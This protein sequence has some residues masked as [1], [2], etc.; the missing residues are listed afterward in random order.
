MNSIIA[1]REERV[2]FG[3]GI[4][5]LSQ[6][7]FVLIDPSAKWLAA[8][9]IPTTEIIFVRYAVHLALVV[10]FFLPQRGRALVRTRNLRLELARGVALLT[11]TIFAFLAVRSLPVTM[12]GAIAFTLPLIVC[13]LSIPMLGEQVGWRRWSA[14]VVG[15]AGVL[16]VIQ[17]G[18]SA[19]NPAVFLSLA[20]A[21]AGAVY[22][23]LTRKLAGVDSA[24]TQQF[25]AAALA[26]CCI[27]PFAFG[28]WVWPTDAP[29]WF[30]FAV[31]GIAGMLGHQLATVAA[32]FAPASVLAPF[33]Y[34][35]IVY[36]A[37]IS[38]LIF[39]QP[40]TLWI[41]L[42]AAIVIASGLYMGLRERKL[43][44]PITP[45]VAGT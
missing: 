30:A 25:Y 39:N 10:G 27:T 14:I 29:T 42:G 26:L 19:F 13:M 34:L 12:T 7:A 8:A 44:K 37:I 24:S 22:N 18:T 35:Q 36:L 16:V 45:V 43:S 2:M 3:I 32:R 1:P 38:W 31:I 40:P 9:A 11:S 5:L 23:I 41:Y 33:S 20:S 28:D 15:F 4:I 17:P 21:T 6:V